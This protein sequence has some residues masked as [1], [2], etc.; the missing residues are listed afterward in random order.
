MPRCYSMREAKA[1]FTEIIL[2]VRR[3]QKV[4]ISHRGTQVAE[5]RPLPADELQDLHKVLADLE[6]AGV[7]TPAS[8]KPPRLAPI[9]R[10]RGVLARFLAARR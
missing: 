1:M 9:A 10:R 4:R 6:D 2:K 7:L 8:E 5:I 3:G